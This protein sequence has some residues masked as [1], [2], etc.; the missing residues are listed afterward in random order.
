MA[1]YKTEGVVLKRKDF[2]E[3]DR[4]LT[5]FSKNKGKITAIAKGVRKMESRKGGNVELFNHGAFLLAEGRNMDVLTEVQVINPFRRI[6]EN[7]K[8]VSYT[9]HVVELV[10]Q[11]AQENQ[12]NNQVFKLLLTVLGSVNEEKDFSQVKTSLRA[13]EIKLLNYF[14]FRPQLT[15]CVKCFRILFPDNN[16]FSQS[17]GGIVCSGC[18]N[19]DPDSRPVSAEAIKVLRFLQGE[20]WNQVEK[21]RIPSALGMELEQQLRDYLEFLLERELK[22]AKFVERVD[23]R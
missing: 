18:V 11:F 15:N 2:G 4:I 17:L 23:G 16:R 6:R 13:F 22:S 14:G 9:Y 12:E 19:I 20:P 21:L 5:I 10:D 3:A 8:L 7:L 1:T